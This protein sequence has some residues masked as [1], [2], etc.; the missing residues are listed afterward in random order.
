MDFKSAVLEDLFADLVPDIFL[1]NELR[2]VRREEVQH[3]VADRKFAAVMVGDT[4]HK[5]QYMLPGK[6]LGYGVRKPG[7][8]PYPTP[9]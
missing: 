2:G 4:I 9:A 5:W 1:R 6:L 3:D 8:I 7:S